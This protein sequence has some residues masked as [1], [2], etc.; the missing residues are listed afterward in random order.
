MPRLVFIR[1][2][3]T[4]LLAAAVA[5][6]GVAAQSR[7]LKKAAE[8]NSAAVDGVWDATIQLKDAVVPFRL[9]LSGDAAHVQATYFDG[10]RPVRASIV[11]CVFAKP[12]VE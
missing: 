1:L 12:T 11:N 4:T 6:G 8:P 3:A 9:R 10:E 7:E 5:L 2:A